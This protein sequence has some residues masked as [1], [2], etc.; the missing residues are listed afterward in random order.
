MDTAEL[1]IRILEAMEGD[2]KEEVNQLNMKFQGLSEIAKVLRDL[3]KHVTNSHPEP[4]VTSFHP[5]FKPVFVNSQQ[6]IKF[7]EIL[8]KD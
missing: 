1:M 3:S 2:T 6:Q 4:N 7:E 5:D 8:K